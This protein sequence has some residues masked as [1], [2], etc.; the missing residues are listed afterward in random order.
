MRTVPSLLIA[1]SFAAIPY[2]ASAADEEYACVWAN[3]SRALQITTSTSLG[4]NTIQGLS[5]SALS[6][7]AVCSNPLCL[8]EERAILLHGVL[9]LLRPIFDR[10]T[11]TALYVGQVVYGG[12][13]ATLEM[14]TTLASVRLIFLDGSQEIFTQFSGCFIPRLA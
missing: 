2:T 14:P 8:S 5:I 4:L 12:R 1:A 9:D 6:E 3:A 11:Q 7:P 13:T 10:P